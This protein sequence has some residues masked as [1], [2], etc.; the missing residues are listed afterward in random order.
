[1]SAV[2]KRLTDAWVSL[3]LLPG[4]LFLATALTAHTLGQRGWADVE[5][6]ANAA[7]D[8]RTRS[9]SSSA[10]VALLVAA[11][12]LAAAAGLLAR[13]T[14]SVVRLLM[15]GDRP[16]RAV[17]RRQARWRVAHQA[18][19]AEVRR[20]R[21]DGDENQARLDEL[22]G[23][24]NR[25]GLV[26]PR[27]LTWTG[28]R[29]AAVDVRVHTEY[30]L[31][32]VSA[33]PPLWLILPDATRA[34][35]EKARMAFEAGT[36]TAGW[37]LLYLALGVVWWPSAAIGTV[38]LAMAWWRTRQAAAVLAELAEAVVDLYGGALAQALGL[39]D[40]PTLTRQLGAAITARLRKGT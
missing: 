34:E 36:G 13:G 27:R 8:V 30:E 31:D 1:M 16:R 26:E 7:A 14:G 15:L 9:T 29:V 33:W 12:L 20:Q 18:Y 2:S 17:E 40:E 28:D 21:A 6:L 19:A 5:R 39:T 10:A 38:A 37:G 24:R 3:V 23:R 35:L 4:L 32:L 11:L 22:A 25:I